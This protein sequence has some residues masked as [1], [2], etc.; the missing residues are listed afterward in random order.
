MLTFPI[1][2]EGFI[3]YSDVSKKRLGCVLMQQERIIA[4]VSRQLKSHEVNYPVY[5]LELAV[6]MF[7]LRVWRHYL[8]GSQL[9]IFTHH[10]SL[11]YF[12]S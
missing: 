2:F 4:Y 11:R 7:T 6:G 12:M 9:Q 5:D 10:K 1:R 8:Y 3:V